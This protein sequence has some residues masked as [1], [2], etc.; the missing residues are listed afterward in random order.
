M[1]GG[2]M[3]DQQFE[4]MREPQTQT[5]FEPET[6]AA[7]RNGRDHDAPSR[8]IAT[9]ATASATDARGRYITVKKLTLLDYY[10]LTK[11]I[12]QGSGNSAQMDVASIAVAVTEIDMDKVTFPQTERELEHLMQRLDFDGLAAVAEALK[13]LNPTPTEGETETVAKN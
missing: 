3:P 1:R 12:G 13:Q 7:S 5:R 4:D 10:R 8:S 6:R 9:A 2:P 11:I